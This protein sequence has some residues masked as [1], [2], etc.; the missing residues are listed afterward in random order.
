MPPGTRDCASVIQPLRSA[1]PLPRL[2][3]PRDSWVLQ[4]QGRPRSHCDPGSKSAVF[5][6]RAAGPVS[7]LG[8]DLCVSEPVCPVRCCWCHWFL[9]PARRA[10][11]RPGDAGHPGA[12][13]PD[14]CSQS[15]K[16]ESFGIVVT[17]PR[18]SI[19]HCSTWSSKAVGK[20][21]QCSARCE[22]AEPGRWSVTGVR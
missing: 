21:R 11:G 1:F 10:R 22:G 13:P 5:A 3:A 16:E 2:K 19:N 4:R 7:Q 18:S 8:H 12:L 20:H 9:R 17:F 14:R 15:C 6:V